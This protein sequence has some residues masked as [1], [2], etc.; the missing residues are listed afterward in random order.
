M[1]RSFG[2]SM[3]ELVMALAI[4]SVAMLI[5][6]GVTVQGLQLQ[7]NSESNSIVLNRTR[8]VAEVMTQDIRTSALGMVVNLPYSSDSNSVSYAQLAGGAGYAVTAV[9]GSTFQVASNGTPPGVDNNDYL[10]LVD[11]RKAGV[12]V[13]AR[14][15]SSGAPA[16]VSGTTNTYSVSTTCSNLAVS[17][18]SPT[19]ETSMFLVNLQGY[20][21]DSTNNKI[22][23]RQWGDSGDTDVAYG[24]SDM[25][26][27]YIYT[28]SDNSGNSASELRNPSGYLSNGSVLVSFTVTSGTLITTYT[29]SRVQVTITSKDTS[30]G[31]E[32]QSTTTSQ[33]DLINNNYF[34]PGT[35]TTCGL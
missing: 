12:A 2:F 15:G 19:T 25:K 13:I 33:I 3:L 8:R 24:V 7:T 23:Y 21:F 27:D 4:F 20:A 34:Q 14:I 11:R 35:V 17:G 1:R 31:K 10:V 30:S 29:L 5:A 28:S 32:K 22:T 6:Q 18:F 26:L 16:L 9:S